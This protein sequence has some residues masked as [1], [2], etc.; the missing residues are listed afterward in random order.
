VNLENGVML[1]DGRH[2]LEGEA[3]D[4][5]GTKY[6]LRLAVLRGDNVC[7]YRAGKRT[8]GPD[9]PVDRTIITLRF[10]SEPPLQVAEIRW[11]SF[12]PF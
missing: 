8:T 5:E 10:R 2:V 9:F 12:D 4:N 11:H 6:G 1:A 3:V 7:F